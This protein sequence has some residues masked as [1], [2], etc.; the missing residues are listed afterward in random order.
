MSRRKPTRASEAGKPKRAIDYLRVSET[1]GRE[2]TL[3]SFDVQAEKCAALRAEHGWTFVEEIRDPDRKGSTLDRP[4]LNRARQLITDGHA[5][6]IVV[7]KLNR[8]ARTMIKAIMA[9]QEITDAGGAVAS[10]DPQERL[11]DTSTALGKGIAALLF[12]VAEDELDKI[13][14]NWRNAAEHAV[15]NGW[16][17]GGQ[18]GAPFGYLKDRP[19][20]PLRP[21]PALAPM[22][23]ELFFRAGSGKSYKKLRR[24]MIENYD[25]TISQAS[26]KY[27]LSNR[28][29]RGELHWGSAPKANRPSRP[30]V[31][32]PIV[33]LHAHEP[34]VDE[35]TWRRAQRTGRKFG[36]GPGREK[37]NPRALAGF[38]RCSGCRSTMVVNNTSEREPYYTCRKASLEPDRCAGSASIRAAYLE[39][40][41]DL[42]FVKWLTENWSRIVAEDDQGQEELRRFDAEVDTA[43]ALLADFDRIEVQ[44]ALGDRWLAGVNER[45]DAVVRAEQARDEFLRSRSYP[46]AI[47]RLTQ[48]EDYYSL[49]LEDQRLALATAIDTIFVRTTSRRGP[50]SATPSAIAERIRIVWRPDGEEIDLPRPGHR[51]NARP[52]LFGDEPKATARVA[53]RG[54]R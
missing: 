39:N 24:W 8:F 34:L 32:D 5:D 7:W 33:N 19:R 22:I 11:M 14:D 20:T 40:Y 6:V 47:L 25:I 17:M 42:H 15:R 18:N 53:A 37:P 27:I 46:N 21:D 50:A 2:D 48:P 16:Y 30:T 35:I 49:D 4:G 45:Y 26:V 13:R 52:F 38:A 23:T 9:V 12:A 10:C 1:R 3:I 51:F 44:K 31:H 29:Y 28:A 41:V 54:R 43:K 36:L